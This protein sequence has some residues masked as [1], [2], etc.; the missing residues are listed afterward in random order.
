MNINHRLDVRNADALGTLREFLAAW[1]MAVG[2]EALLAP[3]EQPDGEEIR[4]QVVTERVQGRGLRALTDE[5]LTCGAECDRLPRQLRTAC[6]IC[7]WPTPRGADVAVGVLGLPPREML[8][9]IG[10]DE[11][12]SARLHLGEVTDRGAAEGEGV[13][14]GGRVGA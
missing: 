2:L 14:R 12:P 6:R 4:T 1:W 3:V 10:R 13:R 5:S 11:A 8:L 9:V 7:E